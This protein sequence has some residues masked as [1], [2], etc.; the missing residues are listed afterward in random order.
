[1]EI[2]SNAA[3][4]FIKLFQE[5]GTTFMGWVTGIIPLVVCLMTAVNSVIK[6]IGEERV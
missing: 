3:N 2:I 5:G 1:M 4:G 6:L